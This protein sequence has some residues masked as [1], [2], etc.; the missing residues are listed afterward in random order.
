M[1]QKH[2]RY[3]ETKGW[4][5]DYFLQMAS[6][7]GPF[8]EEYFKKVL[9]SKDFVEQTYRACLGLKSLCEK[10]HSERFEAACKRALK[11]IKFNYG[12][13]KNILENELDRE[14]DIQLA[15]FKIPE[16]DNIRGPGFYN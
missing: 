12:T 13:I 9:N 8:A 1:P 6:K 15:I 16:H 3:Q 7:I 10:Y 4:D 2:L 5:A 11:G 14:Q